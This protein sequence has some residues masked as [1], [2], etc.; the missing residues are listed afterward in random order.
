MGSTLL[1]PKSGFAPGFGRGFDTYDAIDRTAQM[2]HAVAWVTQKRAPFFV[3]INI[4]LPGSS[5][6]SVVVSSIDSAV[7]KLAN[8][9]R[10]QKLYDDA[11]IVVVAD[12]GESL[13]AHG[14]DAH[15]IFLYD[16]TVRVPLLL[17]LS[18][19]QLAGKRI[20]AHVRTL[21]IAPAALEGAGIPVPSQMQ[22]Q[23]LLRIAKAATNTDLPVYSR[24]DFPQQAFEWSAIE[25]WRT[26]KY[27]YVRAPKP[28]LYDLSAD[29]GATH[30]LS[31]SS[32][33]ILQTLASQLDGFDAHFS[34]GKNSEAQLT[35]SEMQ[36]LASL[37]Y[38]G[39]QKTPS[40]NTAADGIDPKDAIAIANQTLAA[41]SDLQQGKV[42][43]AIAGFQQAPIKQ[44]NIYLAQYGLGRGLA[45]KQRYAEAVEH[46]HK[47]IELQPDSTGANF[48]IGRA[49]LKAGD[50][51]TAAVHLEIAANRLPEF[52][53][54]HEL[55]AE[56]YGKLGRKDDASRERAKATQG[57]G[58]P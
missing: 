36:K 43:K 26:G 42:D 51:N 15:G 28:E 13:G 17:K 7:G 41:I 46:L 55:L 37:G 22:G 5:A 57:R 6:Y 2:T 44:A 10:T 14:E 50:L 48:E 12:H 38:V 47:A 21:D 39:L 16:E 24:S 56:A 45:Q 49:L 58:K 52:S 31:P 32:K 34:R 27:L 25:S 29:P 8:A 35:S 3:W 40:S 19:N 33:A 18:G 9:L 23:S 54:V 11:I 4:A 20:T 30:N 53:E 1:D